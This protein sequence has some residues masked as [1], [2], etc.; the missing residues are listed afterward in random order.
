MRRLA[1][2]LGSGLVRRDTLTET[3]A[4]RCAKQAREK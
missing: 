4:G 1:F 2:G 3:S